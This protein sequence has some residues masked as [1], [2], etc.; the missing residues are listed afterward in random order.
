[1]QLYVEETEKLLGQNA[2]KIIAQKIDEAICKNGSAR[3]VLST[4]ASQFETLGALVTEDVDWSKVTMF[5]LDE[6]VNLPMTHKA[7]FR[8]YLM[9][10]FVNIV[11][12]A[13]AYFVNG[14]GDIVANI[15]KLTAALREVPI[16]VGV[17]GI[18]ENAH[19]AFNDPPANFQTTEAYMVVTLS[20]RCKLQQLGEGWFKSLSEV[21]AQAISMTPYQIMQCKY[22]VAPVP[23]KRK[24]QA[25][26]DTLAGEHPDPMV[27][28]TL[29]K[30]HDHFSLLIDA[31]SAS[32]CSR[33]LL[34]LYQ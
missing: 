20:E 24:A 25:I 34:D 7:S 1:M 33:D 28:A 21:P 2:A 18:G 13:K 29:L 12:P 23:G 9:D 27:P 22:L 19:I 30:T 17:I 6:Y 15:A 14:E 10:R 26:H 3:I 31:G 4:G 16:D 32:L 11:H 5:H 8:K